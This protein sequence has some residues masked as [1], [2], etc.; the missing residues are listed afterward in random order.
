[1]CTSKNTHVK[2]RTTKASGSLGRPLSPSAS[3]CGFLRLLSLLTARALGRD[4]HH[5][6]VYADLRS[7]AIVQAITPSYRRSLVTPIHKVNAES[8]RMTTPLAFF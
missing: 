2:T 5:L 4:K 1:M 8:V 3:L 7:N 6:R